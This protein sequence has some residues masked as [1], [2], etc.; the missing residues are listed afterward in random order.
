MVLKAQSDFGGALDLV[1][2]GQFR[3]SCTGFNATE[4]RGKH[5][6]AC[7]YF[8]DGF[9]EELLFISII[10]PVGTAYVLSGAAKGKFVW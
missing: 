6:G 9:R 2:G 5:G 8:Q 10:N 1:G 4:S 7:F 3:H